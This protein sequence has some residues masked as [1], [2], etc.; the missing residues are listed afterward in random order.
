MIRKLSL[1]LL[2]VAIIGMMTVTD[3][4]AQTRIRFA[5]G[6][7]SATVTGSLAAGATRGF[8]LRASA[9]QTLTATLSCGNGKCDFTQGELHDTS[10]SNYVEENGDVYI[11]IDNHGNRATRFTMTVSIQ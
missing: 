6:R 8:V 7:S 3:S 11:S 1:K 10:Y 9:G 4:F 5:R 2:I